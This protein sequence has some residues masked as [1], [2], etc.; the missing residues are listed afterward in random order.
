MPLPPYCS[1]SPLLNDLGEVV[2]IL[3]I[4]QQNGETAVE[5]PSQVTV[6]A[7]DQILADVGYHST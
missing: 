1:G 5:G 3:T 4:K 2:G 7:L 6:G